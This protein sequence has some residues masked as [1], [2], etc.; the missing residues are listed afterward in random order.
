M[1]LFNNN[2]FLK[3]DDYATPLNTWLDIKKFIPNNK[4][5][6]APFYLDGSQ[7]KMFL[8]M[9]F[10]IYHEK[11]DFFEYEPENYDLIIDN[12][13]FDNK[14]DVLIRLKNLDKPFIII[15]PSS[16]INTGFFRNIFKNQIQIIIPKKR[17]N[18]IKD[19]KKETNR[20]NFDCFYYCYKMNLKDD[21]MWI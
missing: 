7:K 1:A 4:K 15:L 3:Y 19:G 5:I 20:C 18:F 6:W 21:I 10:E 12:P 13:P 11:K 9:G 17:I 8:K 16:T 14:K 2:S